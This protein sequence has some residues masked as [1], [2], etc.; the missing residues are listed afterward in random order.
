MEVDLLK[1][2]D[3]PNIVK[4][5]DTIQ[6]GHQLCIVLEFVEGGS[7]AQL[8]KRYGPLTETLVVIYVK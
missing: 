5:V 7:L 3:H 8:I 2:L 4:Y 1:K 6:R